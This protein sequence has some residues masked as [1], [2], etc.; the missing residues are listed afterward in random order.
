[1][2]ETLELDASGREAIVL[3]VALPVLTAWARS[4]RVSGFRASRGVSGLSPREV[5]RI[6]TL[7]L[8]TGAKGTG[9][10]EGATDFRLA[11]HQGV[12][13][14]ETSEALDPSRGIDADLA[15]APLAPVVSDLMIASFGLKAGASVAHELSGLTHVRSAGAQGYGARTLRLLGWEFG[16]DLEVATSELGFEPQGL[17]RV[18][19]KASRPAPGVF[20]PAH[21]KDRGELRAIHALV[22]AVRPKGD[23]IERLEAS[24]RDVFWEARRIEPQVVRLVTSGVDLGAFLQIDLEWERGGA[25]FMDVAGRSAA[26]LALARRMARKVLGMWDS[27]ATSDDITGPLALAS[28]VAARAEGEFSLVSSRYLKAVCTV[29]RDIGARVDESE[30]PGLVVLKTVPLEQDFALA[31]EKERRTV[32]GG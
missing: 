31:A 8:A 2:S 6:R 26:P 30:G 11:F 22:G 16:L 25:T 27:S 3:D 9:I 19:V 32:G 1:M 4:V 24:L 29:L 7:T 12:V 18:S 14:P 28:C 5:A 23:Q 20:R 17:G 13:G 15:G 10:F 21:W